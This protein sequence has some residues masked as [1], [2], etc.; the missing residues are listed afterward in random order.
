V[1]TKKKT[2]RRE[3]PEPKGSVN[4]AEFIHGAAT[5]EEDY[6]AKDYVPAAARIGRPK[7]EVSPEDLGQVEKMAAM[8]LRMDQMAALMHM[9]ERSLERRKREHKA[10]CDAIERGRAQATE[11][12]AA[13][14]YRMAQYDPTM[15]KFWLRTQAGWAETKKLEMTGADGSKLIPDN[16]DEA[17]IQRRIE[18]IAGRTKGDE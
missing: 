18:K 13:V 16:L 9:S 11:D 4:F 8:G 17:E 10:L 5:G 3:K 14:A 6:R 12:I 2:K 15:T 1:T 7:K